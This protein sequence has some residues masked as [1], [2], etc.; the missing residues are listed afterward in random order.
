MVNFLIVRF[1]AERLGSAAGAARPLQP[2]V[3][4]P[5]ARLYGSACDN[6]P[7]ANIERVKVP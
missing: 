5:S 2:I 7:K 6:E 1:E 4:R 3:R